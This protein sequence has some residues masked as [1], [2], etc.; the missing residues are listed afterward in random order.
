[1]EFLVHGTITK[2]T[3]RLVICL[4][5][6]PGIRSKQNRDV[7]LTLHEKLN[8][9]SA[10]IFYPGLSV[11][12][13]RFLYT[14]AYAL[15]CKFVSDALK[16]N[17]RIKFYLFGHSFGGYLSLR[18]AKDFN[19][20]VEKI[21]LLSPLLQVFS[22]QHL[23][24]FVTNL[25]NDHSYLERHSLEVLSNDIEKFSQGYEPS[26]LKNFLSNK[27]VKILQSKD[28]TITPALLAKNYIQ[29]THI[30]YEESMQDHSFLS[31]R[32]EVF[33]KAVDFFSY[34]RE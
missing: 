30:Q 31:N 27:S 18:L 10:V 19:A 24:Q 8:I 12:P 22:D 15:V 28:D 34:I 14:E 3:E 25:Y 21:F 4:H 5:G 6:F 26:S 11:N 9:P 16:I 33:D 7:A 13:G 2:D 20:S 1:M 32:Q 17:P 23:S 29:G